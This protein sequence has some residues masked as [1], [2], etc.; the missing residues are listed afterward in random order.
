MWW[1]I[2]S[3]TN[4]VKKAIDQGTKK[5]INQKQYFK[6]RALEWVSVTTAYSWDPKRILAHFLKVPW[7]K[8]KFW[9][10]NW[11]TSGSLTPTYKKS[12]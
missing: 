9:A 11:W 5:I 10:L 2:A 4:I 7:Y 12:A 3:A 6:W 8:S 1:A